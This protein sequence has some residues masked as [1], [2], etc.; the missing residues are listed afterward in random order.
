MLRIKDNLDLKELKNFG[1]LEAE[2]Y[3]Y[4]PSVNCVMELRIWKTDR[5]LY[6]SAYDSEYEEI[7]DDI[8]LLFS[9]IEAGLVE[10]V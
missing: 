6:I 5:I 9:L 2:Q 10:K 1:F 3:Y 8:D 7:I 4:Y